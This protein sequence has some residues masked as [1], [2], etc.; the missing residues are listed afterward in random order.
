MA[1]NAISSRPILVVYKF[2]YRICVLT[3][4]YLNTNG[5]P[6]IKCKGN[7]DSDGKV[8]AHIKYAAPAG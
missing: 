1:S 8:S 6:L 5:K 7:I 3:F 2:T 4:L